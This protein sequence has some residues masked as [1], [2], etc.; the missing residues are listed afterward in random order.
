MHT[1][2]QPVL[3]M[4]HLQWNAVVLPKRKGVQTVSNG[5]VLK[6]ITIMAGSVTAI[7]HAALLKRAEPLIPM[8]IW[9][10]VCS[11]VSS[12][13][14]KNGMTPIKIRAIVE[15]AINHFKIN[16]CI[17]G[18]KTRNHT[19]TKSDDLCQFRNNSEYWPFFSPYIRESYPQE[20]IKSFINHLKIHLYI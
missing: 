8:K 6:F 15:R 10:Y 14:Q 16:M 7:N 19:T 2:I 11:P 20:L 18:W 17:A 13:T 5:S 4:P 3:T 1:V 9:I 12:V